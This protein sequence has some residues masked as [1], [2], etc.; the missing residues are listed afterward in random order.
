M[1]NIWAIADLHLS[2]S[3]PEKDMAHFGVK[4]ENYQE[5]LKQNWQNSVKEND[6]VLIAGD[7]TW[8][9]KLE[10]AQVDLEWLDKLP[11]HK[12]L[13]KGNHD[14]W[15]KSLSQIEKILPTKM[16]LIQNNAIHFDDIAIGGTRL[17]DDPQ[18]K[19]NDLIEYQYNP[20]AN[21]KTDPFTEEENIKIFEKELMRL[22]LSLSQMNPKATLKIAMTH[23]PPI[24][25][26]LKP[27]KVHALL[28]KYG[29]QICIFGHLHNLKPNLKPFFGTF[30]G[31]NYT[32]AAADYLQFFPLKIK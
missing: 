29:I 24:S 9:Q 10:Q 19:F 16:S 25:C 32:F 27:S 11:G 6:I 26:D 20:N 30:D 14:Y 23:Y 2:I 13:L 22:E 17:W 31:I 15:W 1:R 3:C 18:L 4:W 12:V 21:T 7:I 28:K 5:R 8:A